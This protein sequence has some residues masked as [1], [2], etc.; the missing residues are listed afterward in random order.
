MYVH[1]SRAEADIN[2]LNVLVIRVYVTSTKLA[3]QQSCLVL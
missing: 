1:N 3:S 2:G